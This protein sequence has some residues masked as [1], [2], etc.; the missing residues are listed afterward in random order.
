M[1]NISHIVLSRNCKLYEV[2]EDLVEYT[3]K[4]YKIN[5]ILIDTLCFITVVQMLFRYIATSRD[6]VKITGI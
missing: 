4:N 2:N 5:G 6:C 3:F 1:I